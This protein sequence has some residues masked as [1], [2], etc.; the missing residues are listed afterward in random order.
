VRAKFENDDQRLWPG[1]FVNVS[2]T[3]RTDPNAIVVPP[4]AVQVGQDGDYVY[5]IK[6]D[7]TAELRN[8]TVSRTVD[9]GSVIAKGIA[10]GERVVVDGQMRLTD[11]AHVEI[12]QATPQAKAPEAS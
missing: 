6:P 12:R 2:I 7:N 8:V 9:G 5:V 1:Q 11:G 4:A 10:V 3:T